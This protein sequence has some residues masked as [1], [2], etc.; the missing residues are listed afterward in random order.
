MM[1][2]RTINNNFYFIPT[3]FDYFLIS[4]VAI[5]DV[6]NEKKNLQ[7]LEV[8]NLMPIIHSS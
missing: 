1:T 7:I 4:K 6:K 3:Y 8:K 5:D 2:S